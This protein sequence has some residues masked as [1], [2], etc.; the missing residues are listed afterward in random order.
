M[1]DWNGIMGKTSGFGGSTTRDEDFEEEDVW[2][3]IKEREDSSCKMMRKS[4]DYSSGSSSAWRLPSVPRM[5]PRVN[6][7]T[8]HEAKVVQQSSAPIDIPDWSKIYGKGAKMGS[9]DASWVD[10]GDGTGNGVAN[11]DHVDYHGVGDYEADDNDD[12]DMVPPHEW[13]A[14]KLAKSQI[15][16]FSVCEGVGRTLKGRDLS[17][18]RNAILTKTGFLE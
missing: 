11:D 18:V 16:S 9:R 8:T 6:T 4:K 14:R 7:P 15:S 13:I 3:F 10:D 12:G 1:T 5:I 2:G 17:K